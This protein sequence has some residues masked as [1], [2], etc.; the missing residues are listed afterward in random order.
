MMNAYNRFS[1]HEIYPSTKTKH[2]NS[3]AKKSGVPYS[4]M[5]FFDDEHRNIRDVGE[6]GVK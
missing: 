5:V 2:F 3:I 1:I 4:N 6:M